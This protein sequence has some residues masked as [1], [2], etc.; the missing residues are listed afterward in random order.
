MSDP[1]SRPPSPIPSKKENPMSAE[2][3]F[4]RPDLDD[5]RTVDG[6]KKLAERKRQRD[7]G[8][9]ARPGSIEEILDTIIDIRDKQREET[10]KRLAETHPPCQKMGS[11]LQKVA[12][13]TPRFLSG[14]DRAAGEKE[15]EEE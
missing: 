7:A 3:K 6:E 9:V 12:P 8:V 4:F 15:D 11:S 10:R 1:F 14:K 13:Y 5:P 2:R